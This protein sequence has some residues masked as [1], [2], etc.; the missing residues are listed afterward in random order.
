MPFAAPASGAG[1]TLGTITNFLR[2]PAT[3]EMKWAPRV[4]TPA[5]TVVT[6]GLNALTLHWPAMTQAEFA[7]LQGHYNSAQ[8]QDGLYYVSTWKQET[9][10]YA[11]RRSTLVDPPAFS[12][13][14]GGIYKGVSMTFEDLDRPE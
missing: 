11:G 4:K 9:A 13:I 12:R 6:L 7:S 8:G 3:Y 2:F 5:G 1:S 14:E 10:A